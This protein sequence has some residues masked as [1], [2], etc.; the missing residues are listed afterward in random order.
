MQFTDSFIYNFSKYAKLKEYPSK[1]NKLNW[2]T[3]PPGQFYKQKLQI[4]W[5]TAK[6]KQNWRRLWESNP[7][8]FDRLNK[9]I[10]KTN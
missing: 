8:V 6:F 9:M 2:L 1:H 5:K 10:K 4:W 3:K 7:V